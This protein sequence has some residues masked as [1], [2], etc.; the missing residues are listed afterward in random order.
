MWSSGSLVAQG[1][2]FSSSAA[3][4]I[5]RLAGLARRLKADLILATRSYPIT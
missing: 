2:V 4:A 3:V 1:Q 5:S